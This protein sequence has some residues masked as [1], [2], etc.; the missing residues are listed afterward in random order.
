MGGYAALKGRS[1]TVVHI[2]TGIRIV[3]VVR[4]SGV[5]MTAVVRISRG[6]GSAV[7]RCA[8]GASDNGTPSSLSATVACDRSTGGGT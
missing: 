4:I 3:T 2:G 5:C 8:T 1:S 6:V 7:S